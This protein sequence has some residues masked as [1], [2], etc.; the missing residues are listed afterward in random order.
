M[1]EDLSNTS[2]WH[3]GEDTTGF[4]SPAQ[5]WR[6][7]VLEL[8]DLLLYPEATFFMRMQGHSMRGLK[9]FDQDL[10]LV[11]RAVPASSGSIIVAQL[12]TRF[13]VKRLVEQETRILLYAAHPNY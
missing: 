8:S 1:P 10:L 13:L 12:N 6:E 9:I 5:M 7:R 11:D 3:P 4:P 2:E